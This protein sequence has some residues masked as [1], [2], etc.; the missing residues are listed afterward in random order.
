MATRLKLGV[1]SIGGIW[2]EGCVGTWTAHF[3]CQAESLSLALRPPLPQRTMATTSRS[4]VWFTGMPCWILLPGYPPFLPSLPCFTTLVF[5]MLLKR[6]TFLLAPD[7]SHMPVPHLP[8]TARSS[9]T[10]RPKIYPTRLG[11]PI[12][13]LELFSL[14]SIYHS[15]QLCICLVVIWVTCPFHH[16]LISSRRSGTLWPLLT[17]VICINCP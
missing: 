10:S 3:S 17:F 14:H 15:W 16:I 12:L 13:L 2:K 5:L 11:P 4:L 8:I 1:G 6:V 9:F 7:L